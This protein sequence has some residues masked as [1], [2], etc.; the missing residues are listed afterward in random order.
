M[1]LLDTRIDGPVL[2][3]PTVHGDARGFV[4]VIVIAWPDDLALQ[5]SERGAAAPSPHEIA[6]EQ[7]F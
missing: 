3:E 5:V 6:G 7:G 4:I 2:L 1:R